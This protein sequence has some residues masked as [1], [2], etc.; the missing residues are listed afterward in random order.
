[1]ASYSDSED[2]LKDIREAFKVCEEAEA[3]NRHQAMDDLEFGRQGIQ[4]PE[5]VKRQRERDRRPCLTVNRMPTFIR[6]IVNDAR[7]NKPA[8]KVHPVDSNADV[9][10]AK[11]LNG[12]IRQIEVSSSADAAYST[13]IDDAVSMGFGYFRVDIDFA[14]DDTFERDIKIDRIMNPFSV[15]R[16]PRSTAVD[17]SDWNM[18]FVTELLTHDEFEASYPNAEKTD[19]ES[20][21]FEQRDNLWYTSDTVRVAEYWSREEVDREIILMTD[22]QILDAD[23]FETQRDIMEMSGIMPVQ[24]RMTKTMKVKQCVV[25]GSEI[26][27]E[28]EWSGKYIPIVPVYGE[29][30]VVGENR[31]FHS[32]IHFAKD[33]QQMYNFWRTA[34][35]ELVALAPKAPWIGPVGAFNT[36]QAKWATANS[37]NH[38]FLEYDGGQAPQRQ[39]FAGVP[40]GAIQEALNSSDDM[41]SV[42]GM[43][44]NVGNMGQEVSAKALAA[45]QRRGD[46]GTY[47]FVDNLSRAIRHAGRIIVDLIPSVYTEARVLRI[48]GD[49][50]APQTAMV[51][52]MTQM[53]GDPEPRIYDL[54]TGKYDVVVK[55][56]PSFTTQ[57][58][59][60]ADQMMLLVQQFPQ[61]APIIGDLIAKNLDWPGAEEMAERLQK[62]LPSALQ[63]A[64]PEKEQMKA[65]LTEATAI[66]QQLQADRTIF[67]QKNQIDASELALKA[68]KIVVDKYRA[69]TD[70]ME[71]IAKAQKEQSTAPLMEEFQPHNLI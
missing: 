10:T 18:C 7:M 1:M 63:G 30:V 37:T 27:S 62:M 60:A 20:Q 51:N 34:A 41:K 31:N 11:V 25:T 54:T 50:D 70:R 24:S 21:S 69:E 68:E 46:I 49:D 35:A 5:E 12:L 19:F 22:G 58:Q 61:A 4:W 39:P 47:H 55:L 45:S 9:E 28:I 66:I 48:L 59:E 53:E 71:G 44:E 65:Q 29:E 57:R 56:G 38:A 32:L 6:Q 33:S 14:R 40:A 16:D 26:L 52:Q 64:D 36:D 13:A 17:S 67:E 2:K 23:V 3:E 15:Y 43:F 8:I 42:I